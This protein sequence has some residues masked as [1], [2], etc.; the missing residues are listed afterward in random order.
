MNW[1]NQKQTKKIEF[2][3]IKTKQKKFVKKNLKKGEQNGYPS[4]LWHIIVL[5]A[6]LTLMHTFE[7]IHVT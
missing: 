2:K 3:I 7:V 4:K 5:H 6:A 1:A